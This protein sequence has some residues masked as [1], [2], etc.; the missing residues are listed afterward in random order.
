MTSNTARKIIPIQSRDYYCS[1]KFRFQKIDL[2]SKTTYTC[3]AAAPHAVDFAWLADN[4]G[5][6]HNTATNI[7]ERQMM[8]DNIRNPSCEQNCWQ[9]EDKGAVSPRIYQNGTAKTHTG[10]TQSPEIVDITIGGDCNLTCTYCC[11]EFS[12]SWRRDLVA[13]GN[14]Q[15]TN[16]AER[17]K[18]TA[19][20]KV[21]L[22]I[23]Q[24]ELKKTHQYQLL[25]DEAK[26]SVAAASKVIITGGEP[27]LDNS[28]VELVLSIPQTA[29]I[30]VYSGLGVD[31][32]RFAKIVDKI[33][34]LPNLEITVSAEATG[35][36]FELSLIHI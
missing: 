8:L 32:V 16:D 6:L 17:Y 4:P 31:P 1:M 11:K 28:L 26:L 30:E 18:V 36:L 2:E 20:D 12:S 34:Q 3:H 9:A 24:T 10:L 33:K 14:Y 25:L 35:A 5:S 27:F 7:T 21:L 19:K 29:T 23:S 13:N 22:K 15:L